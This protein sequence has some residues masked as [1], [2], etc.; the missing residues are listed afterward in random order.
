M[1]KQLPS[2]S[3][4]SGSQVQSACCVSNPNTAQTS[5]LC[6]G[7][8]LTGWWNWLFE[9]FQDLFLLLLRG[10]MRFP[11]IAVILTLLLTWGS[12][13]LG[14]FIGSEFIPATNDGTITISLT[15]DNAVDR[16]RSCRERV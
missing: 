16:K 10:A 5:A 9:G 13:R 2:H 14:G 6:L 11:V 12:L 8:I 4:K 3:D 15:L 1:P 7:R